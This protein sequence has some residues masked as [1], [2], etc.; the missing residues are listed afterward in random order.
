MNE[1]WLGV[2]MRA[3]ETK[4]GHAVITVANRINQSPGLEWNANLHAAMSNSLRYAWHPS[5]DVLE[6]EDNRSNSLH[7][8]KYA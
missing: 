7:G 8:G 4:G 5:C 3:R 1:A 2:I 6:A